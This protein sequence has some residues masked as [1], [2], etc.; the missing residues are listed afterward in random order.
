MLR[1][2]K[3]RNKRAIITIRI[4]IHTLIINFI[5]LFI[6]LKRESPAKIDARV[7]PKMR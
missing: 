7:I 6:A 4:I 3:I 1:G 2:I 5:E